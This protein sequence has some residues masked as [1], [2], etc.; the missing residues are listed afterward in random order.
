MKKILLV[1]VCLALVMV[2]LFQFQNAQTR[3]HQAA[4]AAEH[5]ARKEKERSDSRRHD[6][7]FTEE[8]YQNALKIESISWDYAKRET[9]L[10]KEIAGLRHDVALLKALVE[11]EASVQKALRA[12]PM[13]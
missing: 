6:L 4:E 7:A 8:V 1:V 13:P 3:K 10:A 2:G 5:A 9:G 12:Y 11:R